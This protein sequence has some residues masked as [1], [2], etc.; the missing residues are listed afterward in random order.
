MNPNAS[1][2]AERALAQDRLIEFLS[3]GHEWGDDPATTARRDAGQHNGPLQTVVPSAT[4]A[5]EHLLPVGRFSPS[6]GL[7][8]DR[9]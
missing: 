8:V 6:P 5:P 9:T 3:G 2:R 7:I 1:A 4:P